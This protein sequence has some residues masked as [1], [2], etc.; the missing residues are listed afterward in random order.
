MPGKLESCVQINQ[1]G[2][3]SQ[4]SLVAQSCLTLCNPIDCHTP[5]FDVHH[6]LLE[7]VQTHV[8][9]VGDA[10]QPSHP[11]LSIHNSKWIKD[12]NVRAK[13]IKLLQEN[14]GSMHFDFSF[15]NIFLD[16][17]LQERE[18]KAKINKWDYNKDAFAQQRKLPTKW[19]GSLSQMREDI[20]KLYI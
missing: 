8:H 15:S 5:G 10:T 1:A 19:K 16:M 18:T 7:L 9:R 2:Q 6:E 17:W 4:F 14:I 13:I 3:Q 12:L 11:L 20:S